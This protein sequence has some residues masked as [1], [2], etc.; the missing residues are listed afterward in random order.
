[1]GR[2][3]AIKVLPAALA[4]EAER[5][6]RFER[7]VWSASSFRDNSDVVLIDLPPR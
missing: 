6:K 3:V 5:L 4:N 1:L 2:E 7:E